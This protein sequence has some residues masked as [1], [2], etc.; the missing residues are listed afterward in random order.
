MKLMLVIAVICGAMALL[1][2]AFFTHG[3]K[4]YLADNY[5]EASR[6]I[7]S[8]ASR[9]QFMAALQL[10]ILILFYRHIS[11]GWIIASQVLVTLGVLLFCF[12]IYVKHIFGLVMLS[13]LAPLG[14]ICFILSWIVLIPLAFVL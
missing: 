4:T 14:G 1:L 13:P 11:S 10:L 8:T 5:T 7:L 12:N 3:L 6:L 2:D 9:Y